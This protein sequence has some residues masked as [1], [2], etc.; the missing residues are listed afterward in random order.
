MKKVLIFFAVAIAAIGISCCDDSVLSTSSAKKALKKEAIFAKDYATA[1][2]K[3]GYYEVDATELT[4]LNQ[5]VA[6]GM[7]TLSTDTIVEK[8]E[9][10]SYDYWTGYR[11]YT[12]DVEHIFVNVVLSDKGKALIIEEPTTMRK[13][14][15]NDLKPNNNYVEYV[16]DYMNLDEQSENVE[17][18][19]IEAIDTNDSI[20]DTLTVVED[21]TVAN[22]TSSN[23]ATQK[24]VVNPNAEYN[25]AINKVSF[26]EHNMLLGRYSLEK[27]KEIRC[28]E[29]MAKNGIGECK[30]IITFCDKTP[31]GYILGA[32]NEGYLQTISASFVYYQDLGWTVTK[33]SD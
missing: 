12:I 24:D 32:P 33:I 4:A 29:E 11:Y 8:A 21:A 7:I 20:N 30:A 15:I 25:Q 26:E 13:D 9:K 10:R 28:S 19:V 5:L 14:I 23:Q 2:F 6:A 16:P 22:N 1:L 27:V 18:V 3:T 31:F 17:E